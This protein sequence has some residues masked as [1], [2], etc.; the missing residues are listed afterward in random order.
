M[1]ATLV[2]LHF[3]VDATGI[4]TLLLAVATFGLAIY[5]RTAVKQG[6]IELSQSQRP[7][8]MPLTD[9]MG[10]EP[11]IDNGLFILPVINVGVG[12]ALVIHA[13]LEFGDANA[14]PTDAPPAW[15]TTKR[16]AIGAGQQTHLP[17]RNVSLSE[18]VGFA[19]NIQFSDVSG[20]TW[21]SRGYYSQAEGEFFDFEILEE[22]LSEAQ[23]FRIH[24]RFPYSAGADG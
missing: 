16:T 2:G 12:P 3:D 9:G 4:A 22:A 15:A 14:K 5:T 11:E 20:K 13:D 18:A 1:F 24:P 23:R 17:F 6:A 7:V 19:F 10:D 8:L 21:L